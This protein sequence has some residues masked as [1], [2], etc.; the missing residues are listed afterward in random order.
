MTM[1][2]RRAGTQ[3]V[4]RPR[5]LTSEETAEVLRELPMPVSIQDGF[6]VLEKSLRGWKLSEPVRI[7][8][9]KVQSIPER[10]LIPYIFNAFA[11]ERPGLLPFVFENNSMLRLA[12]HFKYDCSGSYQTL[13]S[14]VDTLSRYSSF[15]DAA[16]DLIISDCKNG[17]NITDPVKAENHKG[18]LESYLA[19]LKDRGL[20]RGRISDEIKHCLSFYRVNSVKIQ[21]DQRPSRRTTYPDRAPTPDELSKL[22]EIA[23]VREKVVISMM[24]LGGFREGTLSMLRYRHVKEDLEA[25]RTTIHIHVEEKI[26]KGKYHPYDSFVSGEALQFLKLYMDERRT[27][28]P[29]WKK[30][31]VRDRRPPEELNDESPLIRDEGS[32]EPL[33][34]APKQIRR[35]IHKL[36]IK[37]NLAKRIEGGRM[38]DLRVHGIRKF[39][40]TRMEL[41]GLKTDYV[42]Y[43]LGHTVSTYNDVK[44][45]GIEKLR[46]IY[47]SADLSI[48]QKT[49]ASRIEQLKEMIQA[50]EQEVTKLSRESSTQPARVEVDSQDPNQQMQMRQ[51]LTSA[52]KGLLHQEEENLGLTNR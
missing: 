37:A 50:M 34:V 21:L 6:V 47:A 1:A 25:G 3:L 46:S 36:F 44:S 48:R 32:I 4:V 30:G 29:D 20:S 41:A 42:E 9:E 33:S 11:S 40:K 15:L 52:L 5:P 14:Y 16:P 35:C 2:P 22:L 7:P 24:A 13:Y 28:N 8:L 49:K 18:C 39:F 23:N 19:S 31:A 12:R 10:G 45:L 38:Y 51:L 27:G 17:T 26:T 43:M